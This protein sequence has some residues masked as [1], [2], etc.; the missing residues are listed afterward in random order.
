MLYVFQL[1]GKDIY[2]GIDKASIGDTEQAYKG[3][4]RAVILF[5]LILLRTNTC[6]NV[7]DI[8]AHRH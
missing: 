8:S 1:C 4:G 3:L 6:I 2:G 5:T 7:F